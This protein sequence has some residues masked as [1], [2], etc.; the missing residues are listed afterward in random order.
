[1]AL[2]DIIYRFSQNRVTIFDDIIKYPIYNN[3]AFTD[4]TIEEDFNGFW[5]TYLG[6]QLIHSR[7]VY[8]KFKYINF[9]LCEEPI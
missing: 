8:K 1:M 5:N 2:P 9:Y 4:Y 7:Q 6:E 3:T